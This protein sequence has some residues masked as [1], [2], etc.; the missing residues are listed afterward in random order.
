MRVRISSV[1]AA[2]SVLWDYFIDMGEFFE[3]YKDVRWQK[4]RFEILERDDYKCLECDSAGEGELMHVHHTVYR[5]GFK[6]WEY[7][8]FELHTLCEVCHATRHAIQDALKSWIAGLGTANLQRVVAHAA[9]LSWAPHKEGRNIVCAEFSNMEALETDSFC[10]GLDIDPQLLRD[11]L[12]QNK[13][14]LVHSYLIE[15]IEDFRHG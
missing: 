6:P 10:H 1:L 11:Y 7:Q 12:K 8:N 4:K 14:K 3:A 15:N 9:G 13:N 5:K 2:R